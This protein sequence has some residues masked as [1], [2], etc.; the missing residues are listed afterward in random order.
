[1]YSKLIVFC[2]SAKRHFFYQNTDE[3]RIT[4]KSCLKL[5]RIQWRLYQIRN[6]YGKLHAWY[7]Q[8]GLFYF[9]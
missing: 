3:V 5:L 8:S 7:A 2:S 1:M 9:C 4:L 6:F